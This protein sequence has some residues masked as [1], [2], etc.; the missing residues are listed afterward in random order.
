M[1]RLHPTFF[2]PSC[3]GMLPRVTLSRI[4]LKYQKTSKILTLLKFYPYLN[5]I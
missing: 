3:E 5:L 2:S 4:Q 1:D